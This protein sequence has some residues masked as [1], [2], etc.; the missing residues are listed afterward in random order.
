L[1]VSYKRIE[2]KEE[3]RGHMQAIQTFGTKIHV[4]YSQ[5]NGIIVIGAAAVGVLCFIELIA[6]WSCSNISRT[7]NSWIHGQHQ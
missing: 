6:N 7:R 2:H 5:K 4:L 3:K 1:I